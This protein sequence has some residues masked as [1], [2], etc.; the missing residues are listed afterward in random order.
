MQCYKCGEK[1]SP[2]NQCS[3]KEIHM[4]EGMKENRFLNMKESSERKVDEYGRVMVK[5]VAI[6]ER[7]IM[8]KKRIRAVAT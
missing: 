3:M 8:K 4:I 1:Y 2:D 7:K 5:H 6:L